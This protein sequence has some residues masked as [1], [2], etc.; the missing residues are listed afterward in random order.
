MPLKEEVKE[1]EKLT[2]DSDAVVES[3]YD[4]ISIAGQDAPIDHVACP[5]HVGS[6][7]DVDHHGLGTSISYVCK[8]GHH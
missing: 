8:S 3:Y 2:Q 5:L 6:S 4:D 1:K 7:M